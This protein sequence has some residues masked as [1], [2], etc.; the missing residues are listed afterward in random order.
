MK[1]VLFKVD[2][3][4]TFSVLCVIYYIV[5]VS[6]V[7]LRSEYKFA[8]QIYPKHTCFTYVDKK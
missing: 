2:E 6:I 5:K 4:A 3:Q 1:T 8:H 7:H